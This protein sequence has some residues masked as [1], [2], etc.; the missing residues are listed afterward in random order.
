MTR[1]RVWRPP[2]WTDTS[3]GRVRFVHELRSAAADVRTTRPDPRH[4][5]GFAVTLSVAPPGVDRRRVWISFARGGDEP[6]VHADGPTESPHRYPCG[7]LCMWYPADPPER[8]W[9]R[10]DG[11][12]LLL[13]HIV[14]HLLR[15]E[16]WR[17][18]SEWIGE[19]APHPALPRRSDLDGG[20][21]VAA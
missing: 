3:V 1:R 16:W 14:L 21:A 2:A 15:E 9:T 18:T 17:R 4:R 5:G 20:E 12:R 10:R 11:G 19:E 8:R 7:T 6:V 13:G